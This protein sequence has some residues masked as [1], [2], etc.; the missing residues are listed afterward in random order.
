MRVALQ[1]VFT[2]KHLPIAGSRATRRT[3]PKIRAL[4][5]ATDGGPLDPRALD[6]RRVWYV[7]LRGLI[8]LDIDLAATAARVWNVAVDEATFH[9]RI[10]CIEDRAWAAYAAGVVELLR[11]HI[12]AA[13][14]WFDTA[15]V[16]A[17]AQAYRDGPPAWLETT[18]KELGI[19]SPSFAARARSRVAQA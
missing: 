19:A 1:T 6:A 8:A 17:S 11:G 9:E 16:E 12:V 4:A 18:S 2:G 10:A 13:E 3:D 15:D 7:V 14:G 5:E